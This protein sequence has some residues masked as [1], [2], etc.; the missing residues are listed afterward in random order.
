MQFAPFKCH[1]AVLVVVLERHIG[2]LACVA[3]PGARQWD[4]RRR[5]AYRVVSGTLNVVKHV[6]CGHF[7]VMSGKCSIWVLILHLGLLLH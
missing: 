6:K 4:T 5:P 1:K 2:V 7:L 3:L